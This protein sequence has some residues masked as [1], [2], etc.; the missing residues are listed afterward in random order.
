MTLQKQK[1]SP[2]LLKFFDKILGIKEFV[3]QRYQET[4]NKDLQAI[5]TRLDA[6]IKEDET[7]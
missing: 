7:L 4:K 1:A 6:I 2:E 5:Y 3:K